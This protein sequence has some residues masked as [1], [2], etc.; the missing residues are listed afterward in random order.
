MPGRL[1]KAKIEVRLRWK[2][3]KTKHLPPLSV[4]IAKA[5]ADAMKDYPVTLEEVRYPG[6]LTHSDGSEQDYTEVLVFEDFRYV[7]EYQEISERNPP[8][9]IR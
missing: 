4:A 2:K 1:R 8:I 3:G 5:I 6:T 9:P 7:D